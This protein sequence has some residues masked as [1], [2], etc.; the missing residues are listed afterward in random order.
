MGDTFGVLQNVGHLFKQN[1]VFTFNLSVPLW[2]A[3]D[4]SR[5]IVTY[6]Q[7]SMSFWVWSSDGCVP[8][9]ELST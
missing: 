5:F 7:A 2:K 3:L 6:L 9:E 4:D 8:M 1:S